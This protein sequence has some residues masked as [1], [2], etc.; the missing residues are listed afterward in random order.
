MRSVACITTFITKWFF[1]RGEIF[2]LRSSSLNNAYLVSSWFSPVVLLFYS[3]LLL[4]GSLIN[5]ATELACSLFFN[6]TT[7]QVYS[8]LFSLPCKKSK[9]KPTFWSCEEQ[10]EPKVLCFQSRYVTIRGRSFRKSLSLSLINPDFLS[11]FPP[12]H[13]KPTITTWDFLLLAAQLDKLFPLRCADLLALFTKCCIKETAN[14]K[15]WC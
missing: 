10:K 7:Y 8:Q 9:K 13:G 3:C 2:R 14:L 15:D 12:A 1:L 4:K 5:H 6:V 11:L